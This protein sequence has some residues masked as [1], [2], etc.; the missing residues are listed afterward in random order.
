MRKVLALMRASWLE[1]A[2]YRVKMMFTLLGL[3]AAAL[4]FFFIAQAL[5]P[6]M[7]KS[8]EGQGGQY[9][10]FVVVGMMTFAFLRNAIGSLPEEVGNTISSGTL[11]ALLS[12]PT[13]LVTLLS[14]MV[15]YSF[16]WTAIRSLVIL[17]FASVMGAQLIWSRGFI[18]LGVLVLIILAH[19]P[20][21]ILSASLILAFRTSGPLESIVIWISTILGGVYYPTAVIPSW[22]GAI[23]A[24]VPL[25][26]GLRALRRA[27]LEPHMDVALLVRDLLPMC[28]AGAVMF[29][30]SVMAFNWALRYARR[31]GTL[32][33]Y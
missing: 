8:I 17:S 2:S 22:L 27:L 20:I 7:E 13:R 29:L 33:Q 16:T 28:V 11:E 31:A 15:A 24:F 19:L 6:V 21:A 30:F 32:A 14:G 4:P 10:S 23:S 18:A 3:I 9:F 12:T 26:Y 5:Q 1:A 25:T